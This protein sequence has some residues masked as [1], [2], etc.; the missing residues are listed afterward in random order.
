MPSA[1]AIEGYTFAG[2]YVAD[3]NGHMTTVAFNANDA[4]TKDTSVI[5]KWLYNGKLTVKYVADGVE[6]PKDNNVYAGGAKLQ[7]LMV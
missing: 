5:G 1:S 2:W 7:L 6:A 3:E 4:I